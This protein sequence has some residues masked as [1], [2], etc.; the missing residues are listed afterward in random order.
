MRLFSAIISG[1]LVSGLVVIPSISAH[2]DSPSLEAEVGEYMIDIGYTPDLAPRIPIEFDIDLFTKDLTDYADF[3]SVDVRLSKD[4][5]ELDTASIENDGVNIP[6][7]SVTFPEPGGYDLDVRY[8][9]ADESLIAARTFHLQVPTGSAAALRD[10]F[11]LLHY[12][13]AAGLLALSIGI[14]GYSLWQR[15]GPKKR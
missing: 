15:F 5:A 12:V 11:V 13:I 14:A 7:Y 6:M 2:G 8:V 3:A 1:L 4:G 10:G 9:N